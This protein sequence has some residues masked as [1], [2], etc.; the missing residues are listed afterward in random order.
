M[1]G[2][3]TRHARSVMYLNLKQAK[4]PTHN[5]TLLDYSSIKGTLEEASADCH[6]AQL[7]ADHG[8]FV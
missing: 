6:I 3:D 5:K 4:Q 8:N 1:E 2:G 7:S